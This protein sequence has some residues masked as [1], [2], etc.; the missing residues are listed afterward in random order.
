MTSKTRTYESQ[1]N[2]HFKKIN[3]RDETRHE[4]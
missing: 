1:K 3:E 2:R 4:K